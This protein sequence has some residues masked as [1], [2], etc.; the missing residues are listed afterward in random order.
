M[1]TKEARPKE[2]TALSLKLFEHRDKYTNY[3]NYFG[4]NIR[5]RSKLNFDALLLR[6]AQRT[7]IPEA[8]RYS[9]GDELLS[10]AESAFFD[11]WHSQIIPLFTA[12]HGSDQFAYIQNAGYMMS[13]ADRRTVNEVHHNSRTGGVARQDYIYAV[14]GIGPKHPVP[15]S[16]S[17]GKI[18]TLHFIKMSAAEKQQYVGMFIGGHDVDYERDVTYPIIVCGDTH[19]KVSYNRKTRLRTTTFKR[20]DGTLITETLSPADEIIAADPSI[21]VIF[22][23][24]G[25]KMIEYLRF[26]GGDFQKDILTCNN[27]DKIAVVFHALFPSYRFP[28]LKIPLKKIPIIAP[29]VEVSNSN[30]VSYKEANEFHNAC[31]QFNF[32]KVVS[33][34]N[35][36]IASVPGRDDN[37]PLITVMKARG[38]YCIEL[39]QLLLDNNVDPNAGTFLDSNLSLAINLGNS[40]LIAI[41][42][43][44]ASHPHC[45]NLRLLPKVAYVELKTII[46]SHRLQQFEQ[47]YPH[48]LEYDS[49][50]KLLELACRHTVET[51]KEYKNNNK[52]NERAQQD[53]EQ[54][55]QILQRILLDSDPNCEGQAEK[56]FC[57]VAQDGKLRAVMAFLKHSK[58]D[59]NQT[60]T[61]EGRKIS[62]NDGWTALHYACWK[63]H[64]D[65]V[66]VLLDAGINVNAKAYSGMT[67][68]AIA[69]NVLSGKIDFMTEFERYSE[70]LT[71]NNLSMLFKKPVSA[72]KLSIADEAPCV[73]VVVASIEL[74]LGVNRR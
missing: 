62:A 65:V 22:E 52:L 72:K 23:W 44:G 27:V 73:S 17:N 7:L 11:F 74:P 34:I 48:Y 20:S 61:S 32:H 55:I 12:R 63:G 31:E 67:A 30:E 28:E 25:Y 18:I 13:V 49:P 54:S 36:T 58:L 19:F 64:V 40:D 26:I 4:F 71:N 1:K 14:L 37:T 39:V 3:K 5:K 59:I 10:H 50:Q 2:P 57:Q 8:E 6:L 66:K 42:M 45:A 41:F 70:Q 24:L 46:E 29:Y 56:V 9:Y 35:P 38:Q 33:M 68:L 47:F 69:E 16:A 53:F 15:M 60:T 51:V 21:E 43:R